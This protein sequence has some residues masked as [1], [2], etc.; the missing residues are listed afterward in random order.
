MR[1]VWKLTYINQVLD[2]NISCIGNISVFII[3][4]GNLQKRIYID[5]MVKGN[6]KL[7]YEGM[8]MD[9]NGVCCGGFSK[10]I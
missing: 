10:K 8:L 3:S 5:G 4:V 9:N 2:C 7:G 6:M 1:L